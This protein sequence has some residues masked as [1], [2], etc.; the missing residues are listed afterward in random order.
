MII[1]LAPRVRLER[2]TSSL[3]AKRSAIELPGNDI[4]ILAKKFLIVKIRSSK[5]DNFI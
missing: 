2:T 5:F 4:E 3:T 1:F